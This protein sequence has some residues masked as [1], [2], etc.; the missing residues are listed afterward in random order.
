MTKYILSIDQGTT[1]TTVL[2]ID[3]KIKVKAKVNTEFKQ[4]YPKPGWVEHD[5]SEIWDVTVKTI[6]AALKQA[7]A[8]GK[9]IAAI[10]IT[11][12]RETTVL[13]DRKNSKPVHKAIVWQDR[14]T[15][16]TCE[17]LRKIK[18]ALSLVKKKTGLVLDPYF[19]GTKINWILNHSKQAKSL[20]KKKQLAFGTIDT[21]LVWNLTNG[22]SHVTDVSNASRTL[23]M[24][25]KSLQWD[26]KLL[27]LI[28]VPKSVLPEIRSCSE[29][30]GLTKGVPGLP[31]GIP[32]SGMAGDQQAALFGQACFAAG[33]AKC[34]YGTGSFLL[35]NIGKKPVASKTGLLTTVAWQLGKDVYYA[36]EGSAFIAGAAVQWLRDELQIIKTAPEIEKLAEAVKDNGGVYFVP[37]LAG[38]G[39]PYWNP[40]ARGLLTGLTRGSNRGHL[41]RAV[42]EGVAFSQYDILMAMQKDSG[43]KLKKLKVDGGATQ[44]NLLMQFQSDI[45]GCQIIRPKVIETTALGSAFLAGLAVGFWKNQS[46]IQKVF[47]Q[48][49]IFKS[50]MKPQVRKEAVKNWGLAVQRANLV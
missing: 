14:R 45:L 38:L 29:I 7:K 39:A 46:E 12:Q 1:G 3:K 37:A 43:K 48:D 47:Q 4:Y 28:G 20:E 30:Y 18:G 36:L 49:R 24:D 9:D 5:A 23:L 26:E 35:M 31:D 22:G 27:K 2:L 6:K 8:K 44:N 15:A 42:L 40:H 34:T 32:V 21:W 13:W 17:K 11:N 33:E 25:L 10:G 50:R 16:D 19:S 41:A